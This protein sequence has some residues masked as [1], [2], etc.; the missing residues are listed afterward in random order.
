MPYIFKLILILS[1]TEKYKWFYELWEKLVA[2]MMGVA[3]NDCAHATLGVGA[4]Q[5]VNDAR[6]ETSIDQCARQ[7]V[8][9]LDGIGWLGIEY[10]D[11]V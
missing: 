11:I 5:P 9:V 10:R 3:V 8:R 4:W 1:E 2:G 6:C 7:G